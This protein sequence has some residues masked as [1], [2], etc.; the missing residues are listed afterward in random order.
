MVTGISAVCRIPMVIP[1]TAL[2][3]YH[4]G[5]ATQYT[6]PYH[7]G[8]PTQYTYPHRH[9]DRDQC[10]VWDLHGDRD[11]VRVCVITTGTV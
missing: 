2:I 6:Y 5:D 10:S 3:P 8:D 7:H 9:G 11:Q 4:H 1:H